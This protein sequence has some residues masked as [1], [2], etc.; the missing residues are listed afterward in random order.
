[1]KI[2]R[3]VVAVVA[4]GLATAPMSCA[5]TPTG[6]SDRYPPAQTSA[7]PDLPRFADDLAR[8]CADSIGFTGLP[9]YAAT[10]G[11]VH[12][13]VLMARSGDSW[14][15]SVTSEGDFPAGWLVAVGQ[16][17]N[18]AELV[19]CYQRTNATPAGKTCN[20][21]DQKTNKPLTVTM[22]NTE[23]RLRVLEA[24]TGSVLYDKPGEAKSTDCP[25]LTFTSA[26][27]DPT[28]YYTDARPADYR[29]IL[30]SFIAP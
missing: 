11:T 13:A 20:M 14:H 6:T 19:T 21:Q 5:R 27:E 22:Y 8:T 2:R 12:P 1:L 23:Y 16:Q 29:A 9:A 4:I 30:K 17:P 10:T 18:H 3:G 7:V 24:R 15:Q 25:M 28:K 26:D